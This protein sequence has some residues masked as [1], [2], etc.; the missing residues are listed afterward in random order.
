MLYLLV[1]LLGAY[2]VLFWVV[3]LSR[4]GPKCSAEVLFSVPKLIEAVTCL[5][6]KVCVLEK[7]SSGM[8]YS[9]VG[10]EFSANDFILI[11]L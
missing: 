5:M 10:H 9:A 3:L 2:L 4:M 11:C 8:S 6:E 7:I 1:L